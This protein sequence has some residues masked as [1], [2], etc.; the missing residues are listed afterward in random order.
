VDSTPAASSKAAAPHIQAVRW[1]NDTIAVIHI[2]IYMATIVQTLPDIPPKE[3][4]KNNT[5]NLQSLAL[6]FAF[7]KDWTF[8]Q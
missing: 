5:A 1:K 3:D 8:A 4:I 7:Q 2:Y 6:G